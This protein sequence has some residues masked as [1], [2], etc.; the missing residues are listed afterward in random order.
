MALREL[1]LFAG[2]GGG[3]L[4]SKLLGWHTVAAVEIEDY[5]R[6]VLLQRQRDGILDEFPIWDDVA[7]FDGRPFYKKVQI[8]SGG[9][10]CQDVSASGTGR[11][12]GAGERSG[13]WREYARIIGEVRPAFVFAENTPLLPSRGL[14][15]ILSDLSELGY[16]AVWCVLG[17]GHFGACHKRDRIWILAYDT[18]G[19][20]QLP[21]VVPER[22]FRS[23]NSWH[24]EAQHRMLARAR[25]AFIQDESVA[26]IQRDPDG[27]A[28]WVDRL[29][30]IGNGQVP[31]VAARA[32]QL[33]MKAVVDEQKGRIMTGKLTVR[34]DVLFRAVKRTMEDFPEVCESNWPN[35]ALE[36][37]RHM[38]GPEWKDVL[39]DP[40]K[41]RIVSMSKS[42]A[43]PLK[44]AVESTA[45]LIWHPEGKYLQ[46][47]QSQHFE[48]TAR[49]H[50]A[51]WDG[52]C[53]ICCAKSCELDDVRHRHF[54]LVGEEQ[55]DDLL[56]VCAKCFRKVAGRMPNGNEFFD[57]GDVRPK[58]ESKRPVLKN[59]NKPAAT[60][61]KA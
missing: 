27:L 26:D 50:L 2:G 19:K 4:A 48:A 21:L 39:I 54:D 56:T 8:I 37:C 28:S 41:N 1:A 18:S 17:A 47:R 32:F 46:Y 23:G 22:S 42:S 33:L 10:P 12:V 40:M 14:D 36:Y 55:V 44:G 20:Q 45:K 52:D 57:G 35:W 38:C 5:P 6:S 13:L 43:M 59:K 49:A 9:F 25:N 29:K 61:F 31:I 60:F 51:I 15:I 58:G 53:A 11:G 3:I 30:A 24:K 7:T 34:D 16:D